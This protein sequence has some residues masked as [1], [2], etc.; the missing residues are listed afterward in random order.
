M[1]T[2]SAISS[3]IDSKWVD[4]K[5]VCPSGGL[6]AQHVLDQCRTL[7]GSSPT[8]GS[9]ITRTRGS[10]NMAAAKAN[11]CFMPWE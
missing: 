3:A 4:M 10:C 6:G 5:I 1:P 11:R 2:R 7:R 8:M 9:S